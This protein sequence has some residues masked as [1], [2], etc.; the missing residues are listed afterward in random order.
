MIGIISNAINIAVGSSTIAITISIIIIIVF[1]VIGR[2]EK[3][4]GGCGKVRNLMGV[5]DGEGVIDEE[6][7]M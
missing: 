3:G 5:I 4:F 7:V 1:V 6:G 2:G